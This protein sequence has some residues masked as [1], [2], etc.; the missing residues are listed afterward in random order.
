MSD[1]SLPDRLLGLY[2][3][4][5]I[6][7]DQRLFS[8]IEAQ[9]KEFGEIR[10]KNVLIRLGYGSQQFYEQ[11]LR[12]H[13]ARSLDDDAINVERAF[14]ILKM[15]RNAL[16]DLAGTLH[17][18]VS[19]DIHGR[20]DHSQ[21]ISAATREMYTYSCAAASLV[22]AYRHLISGRAGIAAKYNALKNEMIRTSGAIKFFADLRVSNNHLHILLAIPHFTVTNDFKTGKR[23]VTSGL[24]L[25]K[26]KIMN[27]AHWSEDSKRYLSEIGTKH[28]DAVHLVDEHFAIVSEFKRV[29]FTRT[30]IQDDIAFRDLRRIITARATI[31]Y[32]NTLAIILQIAIPKHLNPYEYLEKWF[33]VSELQRAY[34]LPD[35]SKDQVDYL[36]ALRDPLGLCPDDIR[37]RL[38][39]LFCCP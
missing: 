13:P 27:G 20:D 23:E 24:A 32:Q 5:R 17:A 25:D 7:S 11:C 30:G 9:W 19:H 22:Q 14:E 15:S 28:A 39:D 16:I 26:T 38:Y 6:E 8:E 36:I 34:A 12:S 18:R 2:E 3:R 35:H 31:S 1:S 10:D 37:N 21:M 29:V 4:Q 33:T